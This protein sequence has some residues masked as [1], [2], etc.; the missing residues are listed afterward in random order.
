MVG[1]LVGWLLSE[2][3]PLFEGGGGGGLVGPG[4][5]LG[6]LSGQEGWGLGCCHCV[7]WMSSLQSTLCAVQHAE[8]PCSRSCNPASMSPPAIPPPTPKPACTAAQDRI[9]EFELKLMD[10]SSENL[11][12]PETE[13]AASVRMPSAEFQ[14]ICRDLSTIGDTGV[15]GGWRALF[16]VGG[17]ESRASV[18]SCC[19]GDAGAHG[20][21]R[22][23]G[24]PVESRRRVLLL[25]LFSP[26][27]FS[28]SQPNARAVEISVTKDGIKFGT[29][30][31]IGSASVICRQ[32]T[33]VDRVREGG[34]C[35][36]QPV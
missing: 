33:S 22:R 29:A 13:Y 16:F 1:W 5:V 26:P 20:R 10:I 17:E 19:R 6:G 23:E 21:A 14:R 15:L 31:D 2:S 30:G 4:N 35:V 34:V 8:S 36:Q 28:P 12:I 27:P 11:G 3:V 24:A 32:N 9:A 7:A 18:S 25:P